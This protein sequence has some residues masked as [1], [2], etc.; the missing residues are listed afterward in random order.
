MIK[1]IIN[2]KGNKVFDSFEEEE[3]TLAETS[4]TLFRLKQ[5][6]KKLIEKEFESEYEEIE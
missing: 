3:C 4:S 1:I 6:E 5:I 2:A